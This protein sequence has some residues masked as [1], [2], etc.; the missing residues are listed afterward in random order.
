MDMSELLCLFPASVP[1]SV[2]FVDFWHD[3]ILHQG[4][5]QKFGLKSVE[6]SAQKNLKN[7]SKCT[8]PP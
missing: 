3:P 8:R 4:F 2:N 5:F 6:K 7:V 1:D